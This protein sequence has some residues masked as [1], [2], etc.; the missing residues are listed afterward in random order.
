MACRTV[1]AGVL[2]CIRPGRLQ[3]DE[4]HYTEK[5]GDP[6]GIGVLQRLL[7]FSDRT[8]QPVVFLHIMKSELPMIGPDHVHM[9]A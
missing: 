5:A 1:V 7:S 2:K 6:R 3:V 9:R 8:S 4:S